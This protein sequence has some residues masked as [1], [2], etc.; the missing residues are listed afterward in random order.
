MPRENLDDFNK[1]GPQSNLTHQNVDN[2]LRGA[3]VKSGVKSRDYEDNNSAGGV[4]IVL[5]GNDNESDHNLLSAILKFVG[6]GDGKTTDNASFALCRGNLNENDEIEGDTHWTALNLRRH[7][8]NDGSVSIQAS[9]ADSAGDGKKIPETVNRV[10]KA[11]QRRSG[12][13]D[14]VD[15]GVLEAEFYK[16]AIERLPNIEFESCK[17]IE[18]ASQR[19]AN[20]CGLHAVFNLIAMVNSRD[21][22]SIGKTI[23]QDGEPVD[24]AQF[25]SDRRKDLMKEFGS[26]ED[27]SW[28]SDM[29]SD[30]DLAK[31]FIN[32]IFTSDKNNLDKLEMIMKN[33]DFIKDGGNDNIIKIMNEAC[34]KAAED[35]S[36]EISD[37]IHKDNNEL[38][39]DIKGN[40][41][42]LVKDTANNTENV[43]DLLRSLE[44]NSKEEEVPSSSP[45]KIIDSRALQSSQQNE[46]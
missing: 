45:E 42:K 21:P 17:A 5:V 39:A 25:S 15:E 35:F 29:K 7:V 9:H 13:Q 2:L 32:S 23:K 20:D 4:D 14:L 33:R 46:R 6:Q 16:R 24:V 22:V 36:K 44:K 26:I 10:L 11:L 28:K 3:F 40:L 19:N 31:V 1:V 37:R 27:E 43:V 12:L 30:P 8:R 38:F 41:T 34:A 18:C